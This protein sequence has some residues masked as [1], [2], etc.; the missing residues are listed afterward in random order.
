MFLSYK[1]KKSIE[2]ILESGNIGKLEDFSINVNS[3]IFGENFDVLQT[4][5]K[6]Y[7]VKNSIDLIYIDPPFA[8]KNSFK[9]GQDRVSTISSSKNDKIAYEDFL[10][11]AEFLEFIRERVILLREVLSE[12]GSIYLHID[13]K[14]VHYIK[15]LMDEVFGISNFRNDIT[16]IKS[17]PKN[18]SRKAYGNQKDLILFYTKTDD[19]IWND[20]REE[21]SEEDIKKLFPKIGN[22]GR[23]YT[24]IPLHAPGETKGETSKE[25]RGLK[26]PKG[27][28]WRSEPKV[29][30][31]LEKNGLVEWSNSG[32]P[33]KKIYFDE[34][35]G[36]KRQD[37]WEF[38][39]PQKPIYPT[40]KNTSLLETII[41]TSSNKNSIVLDA[42][43]GSGTTLK[44]ANSL[45][46]KWIGIDQSEEAIKIIKSRFDENSL[47][48]E[49]N[50]KFFE[51]YL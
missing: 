45:E 34:R 49:V 18:F 47:F 8:T 41:K 13:Y 43:A 35:D 4:L 9:I 42:F 17:N 23:R 25:W 48:E 6:K 1:N 10:T 51:F 3:I 46:R 36:K 16:R 27:R 2:E 11:G 5:L 38:K 32:N 14:I 40:E 24:T 50:F 21:Y 19:Y 12:K 44:M 20:S 7:N 33:R 39:D 28:H 22:D 26:P 30:E 15:I 29:L 31:E 37:I